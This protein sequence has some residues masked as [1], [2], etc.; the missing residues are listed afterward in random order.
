MKDGLCVMNM[1][2]GL[3]LPVND[4]YKT[5]TG[6][7]LMIFLCFRFPVLL[8]DRPGISIC[9]ADVT[10]NTTFHLFSKKVGLQI[11]QLVNKCTCKII[12]RDGVTP[13]C[14]YV[15]YDPNSVRWIHIGTHARPLKFLNPF[16][17]TKILNNTGPVG[18]A[19]SF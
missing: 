9:H 6:A 15:Q 4:L 5:V 1:R 7:Q 14:C 2:D 8:F 3:C 19:L 18:R 17:G 12:E 13:F 16:L 11:V 10:R